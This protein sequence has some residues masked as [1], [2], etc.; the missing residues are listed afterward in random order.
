M[1]VS[2]TVFFPRPAEKPPTGNPQAKQEKAPSGSLLPQ[3][4]TTLH[5]W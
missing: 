2:T 4:K 3:K 5:F 1:L